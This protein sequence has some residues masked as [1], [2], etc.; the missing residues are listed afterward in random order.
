MSM[1]IEAL[2]FVFGAVLLLTGIVGGGF[3]IK[4]LKIPKVGWVARVVATLCGLLFIVGAIEGRPPQSDPVTF[5]VQDRLGESQ[6][7]EQV[8]VLID[9]Q[10]KGT[11]TV[12][13]DY[14]KA[15]LTVT[16]QHSGRYGYELR[17]VAYFEGDESEWV[18]VG[19]GT[20]QVEPGKTFELEATMSGST[21][22]VSMIDKTQS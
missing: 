17:A 21:W 16:V 20:I 4:D 10:S 2:R 19:Q 7:S 3:E 11:L 9:G 5:T 18:G 12:N 1:S 8:E 6:I 15:S 14:P 13:Q 22:L